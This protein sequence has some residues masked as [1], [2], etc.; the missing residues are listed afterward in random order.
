MG[1]DGGAG[2]IDALFN[3]KQRVRFVRT[4]VN[5]DDEAI[6]QASRAQGDIEMPV[7]DR[8]ETSGIDRY[9]HA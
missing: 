6:E 5:A 2:E 4:F 8:I 1:G 7:R 9:R 3:G